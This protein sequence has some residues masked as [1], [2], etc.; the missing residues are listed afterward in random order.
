MLLLI[1]E[2]LHPSSSSGKFLTKFNQHGNKLVKKNNNN[3]SVDFHKSMHEF[4]NVAV[5]NSF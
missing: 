5:R 3:W 4:K 2:F 1:K